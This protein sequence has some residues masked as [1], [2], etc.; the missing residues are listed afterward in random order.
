MDAMNREVNVGV[1]AV[2]FAQ[3]TNC[4]LVV[5]VNKEVGVP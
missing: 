1:G 2:S 4:S 3:C 5:G